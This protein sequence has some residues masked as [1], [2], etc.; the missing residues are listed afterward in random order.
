MPEFAWRAAGPDGALMEGR[1]EAA[2]ADAVLGQLRGRG[3]TPI[4]VTRA[5]HAAPLA[6][7]GRRG[8]KRAS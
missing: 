6:R 8:G 4:Q 3:L 2:A 1:T 5:E 7:A